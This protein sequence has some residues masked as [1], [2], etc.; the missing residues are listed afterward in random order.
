M[1]AILT[2][3]VEAHQALELQ[4]AVLGVTQRRAFVGRTIHRG[5]TVQGAEAIEIESPGIEAAAVRGIT[6]RLA[7][8]PVG[9]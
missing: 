1:P 4:C 2:A 3:Q 6:P 7:V 8:E 9:D 5:I